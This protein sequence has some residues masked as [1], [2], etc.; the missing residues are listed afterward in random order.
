MAPLNLT[1]A[2]ALGYGYTQSCSAGQQLGDPLFTA[3][4]RG[5]IFLMSHNPL[6]GGHSIF[7]IHSSSLCACS[8]RHLC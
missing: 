8:V 6:K 4:E 2:P 3:E 7:G 1:L 5:R